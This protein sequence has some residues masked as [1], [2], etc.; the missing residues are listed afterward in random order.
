MAAA[1]HVP[2]EKR[3]QF[4]ERVGTMLAVHGR[5]HFDDDAVADAVARA[6]TGM[7]LQPAE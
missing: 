4:L 6:L 7:M 5:D 1:K 2:I 3:S